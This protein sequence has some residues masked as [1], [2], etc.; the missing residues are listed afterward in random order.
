M[1]GAMRMRGQLLSVLLVLLIVAICGAG[2]TLGGAHAYAEEQTY[3]SSPALEI[4]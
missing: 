1:K 4:L 3:V 2:M